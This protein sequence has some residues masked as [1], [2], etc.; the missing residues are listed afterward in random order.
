MEAR[1]RNNIILSDGTWVKRNTV[2]DDQLVR[3]ELRAKLLDYED[4]SECEGQV[5]MIY[6][7]ACLD[8][9]GYWMSISAGELIRWEDIPERTRE[10]LQEGVHYKRDWT[11]REH[12]RLREEEA[13]RQLQMLQPEPLET[14]ETSLSA[15]WKVK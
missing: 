2:I 14:Y 11:Q 7:L 8:K 6:G 15:G 10:G 13:Q 5:M 1:C 4:L 9:K 3:A 12:L